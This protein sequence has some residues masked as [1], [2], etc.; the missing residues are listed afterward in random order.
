MGRWCTTSNCLYN[1]SK[2]CSVIRGAKNTIWRNRGDITGNPVN[3][4]LHE[5]KITSPHC[6]IKFLARIAVI[7]SFT[8]ID[9]LTMF[10]QDVQSGF[11]SRDGR[12]TRH[13]TIIKLYSAKE[14]SFLEY[15]NRINRLYQIKIDY[16]QYTGYFD[17]SITSDI[18]CLA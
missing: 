1:S 13:T 11:N 9:N 17:Q 4:S 15:Q 18:T 12:A 6:S 2:R 14:E 5:R 16:S 8:A 7:N 10:T 3:G